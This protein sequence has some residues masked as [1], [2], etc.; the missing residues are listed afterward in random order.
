MVMTQ[1]QERMLALIN[2]PAFGDEKTLSKD[3]LKQ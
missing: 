3:E 2:A 1:K